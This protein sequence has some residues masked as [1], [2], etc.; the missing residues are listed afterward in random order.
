MA[1]AWQCIIITMITTMID[2]FLLRAL[3]GG[4]GVATVAGVLGC[5]VV[6]RRMA[7]FGDTLSH[8]ALLGVA[9]GLAFS[10][11]L[12][13]A[14][15]L[16]SILL[17]LALLA[18]SR[19]PELSNDTLLGILSHTGLALGIIAISFMENVRFDLMGYLFGDIL[20]LSDMDVINIWVMTAIILTALTLTWKK[21]LAITISPDMAAV[22]GLPVTR[23]NLLFMLMLAGLIALAMKL[24]G[25]LLITAL[26]IIPAATARRLARSPLQ[27]AFY[28]V[29][30]G[31]VAVILGLTL[32]LYA[33]LPAGA[34]IVASAAGMFLASRLIK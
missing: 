1:P 2:D 33:N 24:V 23:L 32:S 29:L 5:F 12:T 22:E 8:A 16:T 17:G 9:L 13:L 18:L 21:L 28:S 20:A 34:A 4:L 26:L 11:N 19:K 6:W 25:V 3:L 31:S 10:V 15:L 7:Y 30:V 27:M 14:V